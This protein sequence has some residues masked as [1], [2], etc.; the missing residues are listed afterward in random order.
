MLEKDKLPNGA[1]VL[2]QIDDKFHDFIMRYRFVFPLREKDRTYANVLLRMMVDRV[3]GFESKKAFRKRLNM[4]YGTQVR[5]STYA[6]GRYQVL[7]VQLRGIADRYVKEDLF[8]KQV[9]VLEDVIYRPVLDQASLEEAKRNIRLEHER[10]QDQTREKAMHEALE[11]AGKGQFL[12]LSTQGDP[13]ILDEITL[14]CMKEFHHYLIHETY[15]S[16]IV[17]GNVKIHDLSNSFQKGSISEI[18][19]V[20]SPSEITPEFHKDTHRGDQSELIL[21]YNPNIDPHDD[22]YFA[23]MVFVAYLGQFPNSLLF[24][25][26]REKHGLC[27]SI[28]A[29]RLIFD[30]ITIVQTSVS[31]NKLEKALEII[32]ILIEESKQSVDDIESI[33]HALL[34]SL[35]GVEES[36]TSLNQR[37]FYQQIQASTYTV[38]EMKQGIAKVSKEDVLE[39]A[40]R[41]KEPFV[42][43]YRG[44]IRS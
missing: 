16:L 5:A 33:Q 22:L 14:S 21:I 42:Y 36:L 27:Y 44:V 15:Q 3:E 19:T 26:V 30:G 11:I 9:E 38:E 32:K 39:V 6:M 13:N 23:Y 41:F 7:E 4:L 24:R 17:T 43:A 25:E 28:F 34:H 10:M 18:E 12:G 37:A 31:E 2:W 40:S 8:L 1:D 29:S 20:F 35:D